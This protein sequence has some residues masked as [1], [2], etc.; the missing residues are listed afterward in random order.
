MEELELAVKS[1]KIGKSEGS[2]GILPEMLKIACSD[3]DF[4]YAI[5]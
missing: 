4:F 2:S 5:S 3:D 1:T